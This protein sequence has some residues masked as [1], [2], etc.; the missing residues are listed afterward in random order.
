MVNLLF[1]N[2]QYI[3]LFL[4]FFFG[5]NRTR[6]YDKRIFLTN[7]EYCLFFTNTIEVVEKKVLKNGHGR[8]I[9]QNYYKNRDYFY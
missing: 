3:S 7:L 4:R 6:C 8:P 9:I 1:F 5:F 2:I